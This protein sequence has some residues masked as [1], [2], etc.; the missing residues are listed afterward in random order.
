M[1][2]D[3]NSRAQFVRHRGT[4]RDAAVS[5]STAKDTDARAVAPKIRGFV[6]RRN[7]E[8]LRALVSVISSRFRCRDDD[9]D[10]ENEMELGL[11]LGFGCCYSS[12]SS[13]CGNYSFV[14]T[15]KLV[16]GKLSFIGFL[17]L[18]SFYTRSAVILT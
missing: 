8:R 14:S 2:H 16:V 17:Y 18:D 6:E 12:L 15:I 13:S 7:N 9:T 10:K 3:A 1:G 11:C 4:R 5:L